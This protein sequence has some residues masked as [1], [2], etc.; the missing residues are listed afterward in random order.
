MA[1]TDAV[2][3]DAPDLARSSPTPEPTA[4]AAPP[5]PDLSQPLVSPACLAGVETSASPEVEGTPG[6]PRLVAPSAVELPGVYAPAPS[7]AAAEL[8]TQM[9]NLLGDEVENFAVVAKD[10]ATGSSIAINGDKLFYAASIF[11][12]FVMYEVFHQQSLGLLDLSDPLVITPYYDSFGLGPR[13]TELCQQLT[14]AQALHAMMSVS[15]NAAAVLLQDLVGAGNINNSLAAL[16][17]TESRLDTDDL[18]LTA[19]DVALLLEI[20]ASG[21]AVSQQ[22]SDAMI[23]LLKTEQV[24]NGL[25]SGV[26]AEA[27]VAHKTG[28]WPTARHDVGLV[29]APS[30]T[31]V[32]AILS[33]DGDTAL[34]SQ[35]SQAVYSFF[36]AGQ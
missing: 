14:V 26:P 11:K 7:T 19:P 13:S 9:R 12:V 4:T 25:R 2:P 28:I 36:A 29:I 21:A 27:T 6:N 30:T 5:T 1:C 23:E 16:G 22:S 33:V 18:P 24:D 32:I 20:I 31:Y 34:I 35:V 15:D 17:L 8:E 10:L 3:F